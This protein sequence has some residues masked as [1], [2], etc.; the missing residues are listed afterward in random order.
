MPDI[1]LDQQ[2]DTQIARYPAEFEMAQ[3]EIVV[4]IPAFNEERFIGTVVLKSR[5]Y[6]KHVIVV[7]D[8]SNDDTARVAREAGAR[9]MIHEHNQGKAAALNTAIQAAR[10]LEPQVGGARGW[11]RAALRGGDV[12]CCRSRP[13]WKG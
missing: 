8:G 7:D 9:V 5:R 1:C 2:Q 3:P 11:G 12:C 4:I 13:G 6:S 10:Q